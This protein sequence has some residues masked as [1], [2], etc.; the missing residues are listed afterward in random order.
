MT[1]SENEKARAE[2]RATVSGKSA[3]GRYESGL[4]RALAGLARAQRTREERKSRKPGTD[5][6]DENGTENA[7]DE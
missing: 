5:D 1:A 4:A 6:A 3:S 7:A 2:A